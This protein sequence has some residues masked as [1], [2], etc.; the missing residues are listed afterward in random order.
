MFLLTDW[1]NWSA[2]P[3]CEA[4]EKAAA[5]AKQRKAEQKRKEYELACRTSEASIPLRFKEATLDNYIPSDTS[6]KAWEFC[7]NYAK[8]HEQIKS[9]GISLILCGTAGT[10]KTHLACGIIR[11]LLPH[12]TCKYTEVIK[13][14]REV[15]NTY[16]RSS[17][18]TEGQIIRHY[19][20]FDLLV[21]DEVGVQFGS[22]TEKMIL[23]EILNDRYMQMKPTV[24]I[25]NLAPA[26]LSEIIGERVMD[27]M[28]DNG[29]K[30][31]LCEWQSN[32]K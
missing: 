5:E 32:R 30:I 29:G 6:R 15:K 25:S 10:G 28:K 16:N 4:E 27:R 14:V 1:G 12:M 23:F 13:L 2:C 7:K 9:K 18:R 11:E 20:N 22:E 21:L 3:G 19:V 31:L 26:S 8:A 24:L 17:E